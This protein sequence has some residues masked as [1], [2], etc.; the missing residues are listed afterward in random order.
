MIITIRNDR[1]MTEKSSEISF[2]TPAFLSRL[3]TNRI[4]RLNSRSQL[5]TTLYGLKAFAFGTIGAM[6]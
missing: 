1:L 3:E 2:V 6:N 4:T 5:M